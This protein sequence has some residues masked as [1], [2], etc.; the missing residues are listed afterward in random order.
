MP[1]DCAEGNRMPSTG[2]YG[3]AVSEP[4]RLIIRRS[5]DYISKGLDVDLGPWTYYSL[6]VLGIDALSAG[7]RAEGALGSCRIELPA[8]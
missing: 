4:S 2:T 8:R 7:G 3:A 6:P 1:G 5:F